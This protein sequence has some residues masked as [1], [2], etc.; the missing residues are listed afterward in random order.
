MCIYNVFTVD[1]V[2]RKVNFRLPDDLVEKADAAAD[3]TRKNRTDIVTQ[4][5]DEYFAE[6]EDD[7]AFR[8]RVVELYLD[9]RIGF[10]E[11]ESFLG[12]QD[13]EAVRASK[14]ILDQGGEAAEEIAE[15]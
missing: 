14:T 3:V 8:E 6:L 2:S 7:E 11:A 4:A 10:D 12:R 1:G 5:L 15:L 13:A 9:D